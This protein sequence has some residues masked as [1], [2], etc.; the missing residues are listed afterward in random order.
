MKRR[1]ATVPSGYKCRA[2]RLCILAR[3]EQISA[4]VPTV[5]IASRARPFQFVPR[6]AAAEPVLGSKPAAV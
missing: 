5:H 4:D 6:N 3:T 1:S 2:V